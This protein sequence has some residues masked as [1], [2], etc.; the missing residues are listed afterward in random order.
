MDV[1]KVIES[2]L[3][4]SDWRVN[5][6]SNA[7]PT[8][9]ALTKHAAGQAFSEYW[10]SQVYDPVNPEITKAH[11]SGHFHIHDLSAG[12]TLYCCGYSLET[13]L[14][15][16]I[17]G[18]PN[19]SRSSPPKHIDSAFAQI[20]NLTTTFQNEIAGAVAYSSVDT[21][22][23]PYIKKDGLNEVQVLQ[24]IQRFVYALNS[25]SR[26]GAEPAFTNIT[27]DLT[28]PAD[29]KDQHPVI[30]GETMP[31]TY[32]DCQEQINMFNRAFLRVCIEGDYNHRPFS[33]P[34]PT[35]NITKD[36]DWNS[37]IADL[38]FELAGKYG[39]PY[40]ANYINSDMD[41]SEAR[42]MCI[43]P[44]TKVHAYINDT[45]ERL[46]I[47][48]KELFDRYS[49]D[50]YKILTRYG[51]KPVREEYILPYEGD[52]I[53]VVTE[54]G[55]RLVTT[56]DHPWRVYASNRHNLISKVASDLSVGDEVSIRTPS[57][58]TEIN[59]S[60]IGKT[61]DEIHGTEKADAIRES[62][63]EYNKS[64]GRWVG[65]SN[66]SYGGLTQEQRVNIGL[67]LR[68][69][70]VS[71][72][73]RQKSADRWKGDKNPV[74]SM[75]ANGMI[76]HTESGSI[77]TISPHEDKFIQEL[78][79]LG[80]DYIHQYQIPGMK[81]VADFYIPS[82]NLIFEVETRYPG[83]VCGY[84]DTIDSHTE[85]YEYYEE[86]IRLGYHVL[87]HN[88]YSEDDSYRQY[89]N[90]VDKIVSINTI[91]YEGYV[92]DVE[93]DTPVDTISAHTFYAN[94]ILTGNC[95]RLRLDLREL[96]RRNGGLFGSGDSTGSVGVVTINLPRLAYE[97][98]HSKDTSRSATEIFYESLYRY[99]DIA[100]ESLVIKREYLEREILSK[101]LLP[102]F[103]T[104]V[105]TMDNHFSTIGLIGMNEMCQN[106]LGVGIHSPVGKKFSLEVLD[107]MRNRLSDYQEETGD[108][109]NLEATP[110]EST[111][112]RLASID[113]KDYPDIYTQGPDDAP[114]Y[115]NSC[116]LPV[117]E[118]STMKDLFDNQDE[119]QCKF[120]GGTVVH[121]Y[122]GG[123][124]SGTQAKHLIRT[125][126]TNYSLPYVSISPVVTLCEE[127][128]QLPT[129]SDTC[130][131]CGRPTSQ[132]Q[133]IT[134]Y[135]RDT[136]YWNPGKKSEYSDRKQFQEFVI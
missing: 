116:H 124:M 59:K 84:D 102:A 108:L 39:V 1:K 72:N 88:P 118:V 131:K 58:F 92:Y 38:L 37:P 19:V 2:Y 61:L 112:Y 33:Y 90:K 6:N 91:H 42:S 129:K 24:E 52:M 62:I 71:E 78:D 64:V 32:G 109:W 85:D 94:E 36:F 27:L 4:K 41:P 77:Y 111:S 87:V 9:G 127:H 48:I 35:Y 83:I 14:R 46:H 125:I 115:T 133:R 55:K 107:K 69:H 20:V 80:L 8:I 28:V 12:L 120:T 99:M 122:C 93:I 57:N 75:M 81:R 117:N 119:L 132:L 126:C 17:H 101:H 22:L 96:T 73:C 114:Y 10:R 76:S 25:N 5:E 7:A 134:G 31:F 49:I 135:I 16:G 15:E 30:A 45:G 121:L 79:A 106:L 29:L 54:T 11:D 105:G 56:P 130:P 95:C 136:R 26:C 68:G 110:A 86:L 47:T 100:K 34:I 70:Y 74:H 67:G 60:R 128:G 123:P 66:P 65:E 53:E 82:K 40:F 98:M 97:A 51:Y 3:D 43:L 103:E 18:I 44:D 23:A 104:Y 113:K 89:L 50:E 21:R 13:I 63:S